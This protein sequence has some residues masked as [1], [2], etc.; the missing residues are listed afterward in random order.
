MFN[1]ISES[2]SDTELYV[3]VFISL[4][5]KI[6]MISVSIIAAFY[7]NKIASK[8]IDISLE[9]MNNTKIIHLI[10]HMVKTLIWVIAILNICTIIGLNIV[11][12]LGSLGLTGFALGLACKDILENVISGIMLLLYSPFKIGDKITFSTNSGIVQS[13]NY[14]FT[15]LLDDNGQ[16]I[17]I[18]NSM[19]L[20]NTITVSQQSNQ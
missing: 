2:I 6:L 13:I 1:L 10:K 16:L 4:I 3:K 9:K 8:A 18:P 7:I 14:R 11:P 5:P 12:L 20:K 17:L 19:L 15:E